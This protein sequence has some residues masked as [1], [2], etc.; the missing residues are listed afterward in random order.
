MK[1]ENENL[2]IRLQTI[3]LQAKQPQSSSLSPRALF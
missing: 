1:S 2:F 3:E